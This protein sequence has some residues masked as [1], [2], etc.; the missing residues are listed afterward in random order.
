MGTTTVEHWDGGGIG[1]E[2][3][4]RVFDGGVNWWDGGGGDRVKDFLRKVA[5]FEMSRG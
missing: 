3:A 4:L 5:Q 2:L 1:H